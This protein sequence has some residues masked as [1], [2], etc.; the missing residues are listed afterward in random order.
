MPE[1]LV[2]SPK[3][4]LKL[5]SHWSLIFTYFSKRNAMSLKLHLPH[6]IRG[7]KFSLMSGGV[8]SKVLLESWGQILISFILDLQWGK[9]I[10]FNGATPGLLHCEIIL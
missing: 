9:S 7:E 6:V 3:L 8:I 2:I 10:N 5:S 1:G 4:K